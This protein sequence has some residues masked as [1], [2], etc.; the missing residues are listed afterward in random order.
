VPVEFSTG[1]RVAIATFEQLEEV[2]DQNSNFVF[3]SFSEPMEGH[4]FLSTWH[5][6]VY[7]TVC[8]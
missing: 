3:N 7:F 8:T 5:M 1:L 6:N 4:L 2:E